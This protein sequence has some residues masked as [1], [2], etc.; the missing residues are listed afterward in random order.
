MRFIDH[1]NAYMAMIKSRLPKILDDVGL[2]LRNTMV[3]SMQK[4]SPPPSAPGEVPHVASGTLKR[5]IT[6][7][8]DV[9]NLLVRA[10]CNLEYG[11]WLATGTHKM[12]ARPWIRPAFEKC[13]KQIEAMF[14]L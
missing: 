9:P 1:R 4:E 7:E 12:K 5:D 11:R 10:G 8:V 3:E 6:Y 14:R 2:L 13:K